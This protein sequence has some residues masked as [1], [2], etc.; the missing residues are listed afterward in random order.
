MSLFY[1]KVVKDHEEHLQ[2]APPSNLIQQVSNTFKAVT[3][4]QHKFLSLTCIHVFLTKDLS[5]FSPKK[6]S[7]YFR[8]T[9]FHKL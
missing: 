2:K 6:G 3:P 7:S 1:N 9:S 5:E 4:Q 8:E